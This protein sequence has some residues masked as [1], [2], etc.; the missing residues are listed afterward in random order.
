MPR[1]ASAATAPRKPALPNE[2]FWYMTPTRVMP[3]SSVSRATIS[4][5]S[6]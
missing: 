3:R 1:R 5:V 6:W 4:S 2:S